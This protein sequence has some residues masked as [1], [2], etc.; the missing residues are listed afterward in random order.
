MGETPLLQADIVLVLWGHCRCVCM[1]VFLFVW[2]VFCSMLS[3][4]AWG[5]HWGL[6][7]QTLW[8]LCFFSCLLFPLSLPLSLPHI[9]L[10]TLVIISL[11]EWGYLRRR[12]KEGWRCAQRTM[13][14]PLCGG[15]EKWNFIQPVLSLFSVLWKVAESSKSVGRFAAFLQ[16]SNALNLIRTVQFH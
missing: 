10:Q 8:S 7:D 14:N 1:R 3:K 12:K 11:L 6:N 13:K 5:W 9:F 4:G 15:G 2:C 16:T